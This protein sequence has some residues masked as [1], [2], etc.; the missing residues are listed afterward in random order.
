[1][2]K[3]IMPYS[4]IKS[5]QRNFHI[6]GFGA[7]GSLLALIINRNV[8]NVFLTDMRENNKSPMK[9]RLGGVL[10]SYFDDSTI[11]SYRNSERATENDALFI[12]IKYSTDYLSSLKLVLK[13]FSAKTPVLLLQ[14]SYKHA[15]ILR[16]SFDN[17][18][19]VGMLSDLE[20]FYNDGVLQLSSAP[21]TVKIA[22][23]HPG[24]IDLFKN[25]IESPIVKLAVGGSEKYI[26][27]QKLARWVPLSCMTTITKM[28]I[29]EA[30]KFFPRELLLDL[31]NEICLLA[32]S[33]SNHYFDKRAIFDQLNSLPK[34]LT[35]SSMRDYMIYKRPE[36]Q[37]VMYEIFRDLAKSKLPCAAAL[38]T[39]DLMM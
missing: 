23:S 36:V 35:T 7:V 33:E 5:R 1:M 19:V 4:R 32:E 12:C 11:F 37:T 14:N 17:P 18:F 30:L 15:E 25:A 24:T 22:D 27:W 20:V 38:K 9:I 6:V 29:G 26:I 28:N 8:A 16:N 2:T 13:E 39:L 21:F 3:L 10:S 34:N 31:I